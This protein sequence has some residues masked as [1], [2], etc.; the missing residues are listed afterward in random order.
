MI[1]A[2]LLLYDKTTAWPGTLAILPVFGTALVL[3]AG[4]LRPA[5]AV[6]GVIQ[7]LGKT[8]FSLYLW[9]WPVFVALVFLDLPD[10]LGAIL[11]SI[12]L[13]ALLATASYSLIEQPPPMV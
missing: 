1:F 9:H 13:S 3:L 11:G 5:W 10:Q 12:G 7:W 8:Y 2:A 6:P 4:K